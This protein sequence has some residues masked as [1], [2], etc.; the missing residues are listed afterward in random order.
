VRIWSRTYE[1]ET[2]TQP[3]M[4]N[5][6][7]P[8]TSDSGSRPRRSLVRWRTLLLVGGLALGVVGRVLSPPASAILLLVAGGLLV[9]YVV[10]VRREISEHLEG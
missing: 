6:A 2:G 5:A 9:S 8:V 3:G 7:R 1:A 4:G 10:L